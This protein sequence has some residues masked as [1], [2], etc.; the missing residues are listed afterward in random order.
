MPLV[1]VRDGTGEAPILFLQFG[2]EQVVHA[3][4]LGDGLH[5]DG[6]RGGHDGDTVAHFAVPFDQFARL[7]VDERGDD[8][9]QGVLGD[10]AQGFGFA[11]LDDPSQG[12][13][14]GFQALLGVGGEHV[15]AQHRHHLQHLTGVEQAAFGHRAAVGQGCRRVDDGLIEVEDGQNSLCARCARWV[16]VLSHMRHSSQIAPLMSL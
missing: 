11:V 7:G 13:F 1:E 2:G 10:L 6:G 14:C 8:F 4:F 15:V 3:E 9:L 16:L 5:H 12:L